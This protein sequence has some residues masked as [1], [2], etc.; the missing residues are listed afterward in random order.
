MGAGCVPSQLALVTL[1]LSP[2]ATV[3]PCTRPWFAL[4]GG[5]QHWPEKTI[6]GC[7][8]GRQVGK[9]GPSCA[10]NECCP[11]DLL[12]SVVREFA[13]QCERTF[14]WDLDAPSRERRRDCEPHRVTV[15]R[16]GFGQAVDV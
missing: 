2:R 11:L 10:A 5:L 13:G 6:K 9:V 3:R 4:S 7:N 12:L 8:D 15:E 16:S 14:V 1:R